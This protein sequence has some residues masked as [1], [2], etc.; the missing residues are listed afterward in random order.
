MVF[1][2][3][4]IWLY[5]YS[6]ITISPIDAASSQVTYHLTNQSSN[7]VV[8]FESSGKT[9]KKLVARGSYEIVATQGSKSGFVVVKTGGFLMSKSVSLKLVSERTRIYVGNNPT[10]C[11]FY[12]GVLL[13]SY[14]CTDIDGASVHQPSTNTQPTATKKISAFESGQVEG[15]VAT[16]EGIVALVHQHVDSEDAP[17]SHD[18]VLLDTQYNVVSSKSISEF[19][20]TERL[21]IKPFRDGFIIANSTLG[22]AF[23]YSSIKGAPSSLTLNSSKNTKLKPYYITTSGDAYLVAYSKDGDG[24]DSAL[25]ATKIT[26]AQTNIVI[27]SGNTISRLTVGSRPASIEFCDSKHLCILNNNQLSVYVIAGKKITYAY[28]ITGVDSIRKTNEG[29]VFAKNKGI[30]GMDVA[31][32]S[33]YMEYSLGVY[34]LCGIKDAINGY[35]LCLIDSRQNKVALHI[36]PKNTD[37]DEID[38]KITSI[39][40]L[41]EVSHISVYGNY[42]YISPQAGTVT[43]LPAIQGYG[44]DPNLLAVTKEKILTSVKRLGID[45]NTYKIVFTL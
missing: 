42:L 4:G 34:S 39:Q 13:L 43:Y 24:G 37:V 16:Y 6:F 27:S 28:K 15:I 5:G 36:D 21:T 38:K 19:N 1:I 29:L 18:L 11:M 33:G 7:K 35:V 26:N 30:W 2:I 10:G 8:A 41:P 12:S 45:T 20:A 22:S 44:Y 17:P 9:V 40:S 25:D 14:E 23:Y 32:R 31:S 3:V